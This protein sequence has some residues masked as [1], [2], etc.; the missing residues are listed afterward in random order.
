MNELFISIDALINATF[1][2]GEAREADLDGDVVYVGELTG[3]GGKAVVV[4]V[5]VGDLFAALVDDSEEALD[6]LAADD[7]GY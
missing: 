7:M 4:P 5:E 3:G 1:A 2:P 6:L